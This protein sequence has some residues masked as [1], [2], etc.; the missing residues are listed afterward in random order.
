MEASSSLVADDSGIAALRLLRLCGHAGDV[1]GVY[2]GGGGLVADCGGRVGIAGG[3]GTGVF[4]VG[5]QGSCGG[6]ALVDDAAARPVRV[7]SVGDGIV[8]TDGRV[9]RDATPADVRWQD[10][11][12][13]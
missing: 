2:R 1:R 7:R 3:R 9:A 8:R 6:G 11:S 13:L 10:P 12:R 4:R 5:A